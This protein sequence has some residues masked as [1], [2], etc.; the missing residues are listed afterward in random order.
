MEET[1][2]ANNLHS[3]QKAEPTIK[4]SPPSFPNGKIKERSNFIPNFIQNKKKGVVGDNSPKS[5]H[6]KTVI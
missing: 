6:N 5:Y 2:D 3:S 1:I 4:F